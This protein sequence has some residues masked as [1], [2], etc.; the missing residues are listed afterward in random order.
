MA[1]HLGLAASFSL[2]EQRIQSAQ[3]A[4]EVGGADLLPFDH[5]K[6]PVH[7]LSI[8]K[9]GLSVELLILSPL[10]PANSVLPSLT[11]SDLPTWLMTG[12]SSPVH[13]CLIPGD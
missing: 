9:M 5:L 1:A 10:S 12:F 13:S 8:C 11:L 6:L 4:S 7:G 3:R 2:T